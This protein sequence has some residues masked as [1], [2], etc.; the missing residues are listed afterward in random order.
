MG[1]TSNL[2]KLAIKSMCVADTEATDEGENKNPIPQMQIQNY[3][4]V[5]TCGKLGHYGFYGNAPI[6]SL[7]MVIQANGQEECLFGAEDDVNNRPRGLSE[8]EVMMYNTVTKNYIY[9]DKD[10][11][12]KIYA[13]KDMNLQV[14][15]NV[16][17]SVVGNVNLTAQTTTVN[18]NAV[19]NGNTT[20]NGNLTV[21]GT[22][23]AG[24]VEAGNGTD[25]TFTNSVTVAKG[26]TTSGS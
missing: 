24:T 3:D 19:V 20:M 15:G 6:G 17:I 23:S 7:V 11:N 2:T 14:S 26:I 22:M 25:G 4:A 16:N 8:G 21:S 10:G 5:K 12:T 1:N 9:F 13:K 18:G